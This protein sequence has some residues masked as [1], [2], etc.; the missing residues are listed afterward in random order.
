MR[1]NYT[2]SAEGTIGDTT[3]VCEVSTHP[4]RG[5]KPD[6]GHVQEAP[7]MMLRKSSLLRHQIKLGGEHLNIYPGGD[8]VVGK[9]SAPK[10]R[11]R[12]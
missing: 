2:K 6:K 3:S 8:I 4:L 11:G 1:A 9:V 10:V 12:L 7:L 5:A